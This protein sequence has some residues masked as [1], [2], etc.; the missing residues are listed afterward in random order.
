MSEDSVEKKIDKAKGAEVVYRKFIEKYNQGLKGIEVND[1]NRFA[2]EV[3]E[4]M[5]AL[6]A[7]YDESDQAK[8]SLEIL[9]NTLRG[10]EG[11]TKRSRA[12]LDGLYNA[13]LR[14]T[15]KSP[16]TKFYDDFLKIRRGETFFE[17]EEDQKESTKMLGCFIPGIIWRYDGS[18]QADLALGMVQKALKETKDE[19]KIEA[20]IKGLLISVLVEIDYPYVKG[21]LEGKGYNIIDE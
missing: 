3:A 19:T 13:S 8:F 15:T 20:L 21:L 5:P 7:Y 1:P 14:M 16:S 9:E 2:S 6:I 11:D 4:W 17:I 18:F 10:A 12:I